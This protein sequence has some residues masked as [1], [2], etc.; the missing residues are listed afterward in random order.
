MNYINSEELHISEQETSMRL[1]KFLAEKFPDMS[2]S[3]IQKQI[4][5]GAVLINGS[6][7][8]T[9]YKIC[10]T[11]T[12]TIQ[13]PKPEEPIAMPEN[14]PL[15]IIYEDDD[16]IV[17]NKPKRMVVHPA[18][19]HFSGTVVNALLYHCKDSLSGING[20]L[21]P[22]IVHRIDQDTTGVIV[23]CKNDNSHRCL[24]EQLK[25]H[26]ITRT[27]HAIVNNHLKEEEGTIKS[28]IGRN[29]ANR[30]KM[31]AGVKDGRDAI[32]HYKVLDNLDNRHTYVECRLETGRTHQIRVHMASIGYPVLGDSLYGPTKCPFTLEG[33]VLHA[34]TLGFIHP[35]LKKYVEFEAPL[36]KYF[37]KLL[38]ILRA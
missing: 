34:K 27:Y 2:R 20:I 1:D 36:P 25:E 14:I 5:D 3:Y 24:A 9:G 32:T 15:D 12:I 33:Q 6:K 30:K 11:D 22:G 7:T 17:I 8:K 29:P 18:P 13:I 19:G 26:S 38:G 23:A 35:S 37:E 31:A 28:T 21:R 4:K 16:I 10:L